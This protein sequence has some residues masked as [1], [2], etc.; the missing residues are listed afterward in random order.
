MKKL[1]KK[2]LFDIRFILL[3]IFVLIYF[4]IIILK[5]TYKPSQ[6]SEHV[7]GFQNATV[8]IVVYGD[9]QCLRIRRF[10]NEIVPSL[11]NDYINTGKAKLIFKQYPKL[12]YNYSLEAA[13]ASECAADQGKFWEYHELLLQRVSILCGQPGKGLG[14]TSSD[15]KAYAKELKLDTGLFNACLDSGAMLSR[16]QANIDELHKK[17]MRA[18]GVVFIN[19][20]MISGNRPYEEFQSKIEK[21]LNQTRISK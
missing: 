6:F 5:P 12:F 15:L 7:K 3:F 1:R 2:F 13:E 14:L 8:S 21:I 19:G 10:W 16:I 11:E 20:E 9:Y 4:L 17:G 18:S